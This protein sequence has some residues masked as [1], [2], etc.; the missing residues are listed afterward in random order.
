MDERFF[1]LSTIVQWIR[2]LTDLMSLCIFNEAADT[3]SEVD[4]LDTLGQPLVH[5]KLIHIWAYELA[6]LTIMQGTI[7]L[8]ERYHGTSYREGNLFA[9]GDTA[10]MQSVIGRTLSRGEHDVNNNGI[11]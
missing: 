8:E 6:G 10:E 4:K 5:R 7:R 9:D 1:K 2:T 3:V 11:L